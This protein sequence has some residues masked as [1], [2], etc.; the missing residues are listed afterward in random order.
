[1][2][3]MIWDNINLFVERHNA[4]SFTLQDYNGDDV[5]IA[6]EDIIL[7]L[8]GRKGEEALLQLTQ[9]ENDNGSVVE[10]SQRSAP[11]TC[12]INITGDDALALPVSD[13]D[14]DLVGELLVYDDSE[15]IYLLYGRGAITVQ[16]ST[17]LQSGS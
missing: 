14:E 7:F 16:D 9:T 11:A 12:I 3:S 13:E 2:P 6:N 8:V 10:I 15:D 17:L 5:A 1:M 4:F